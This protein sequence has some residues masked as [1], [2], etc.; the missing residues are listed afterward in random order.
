MKKTAILFGA[1]CCLAACGTQSDKPALL[2]AAEADGRINAETRPLYENILKS[3]PEEGA[4]AL[5]ALSPK[6]KVM[7]DIKVEP[8]GKSPWNKRMR[9]IKDKLN[10]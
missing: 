5:A 2:D 7:E 4:K 9:E 3:N 6:R 1:L 10:K 8:E